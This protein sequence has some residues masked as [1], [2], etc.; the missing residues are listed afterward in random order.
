MGAERVGNRK[1]ESETKGN[2]LETKLARVRNKSERV[3]R[4]RNRGKEGGV[5]QRGK[6]RGDSNA[7]GTAEG[8]RTGLG[9]APTLEDRSDR[10]EKE[11][12][13]GQDTT[14]FDAIRRYLALF[15]AILLY[16]SNGYL[17][18]RSPQTDM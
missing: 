15:E 3:S 11:R 1:S 9:M 18:K 2:E 14:L 10:R 4:D 12:Q 16:L 8:N 17:C 7:Q 6:T 13:D 5:R